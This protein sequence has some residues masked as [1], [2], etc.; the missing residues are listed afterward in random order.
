[1]IKMFMQPFMPASIHSKIDRFFELYKVTF[2]FAIYCIPWWLVNQ[3]FKFSLL[4]SPL[5]GLCVLILIP[6][7]VVMLHQFGQVYLEGHSFTLKEDMA[8]FAQRW[9]AFRQLRWGFNAVV[10]IIGMGFTFEF[11]LVM[12]QEVLH[13][14]IIPFLIIGAF[15]NGNAL[16]LPAG[17]SN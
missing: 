9:R 17:D 15:F 13:F 1:M 5:Y 16:E 14:M 11:L 6:N 4:T 2:A 8:T 3:F 12:R 7:V 10:T